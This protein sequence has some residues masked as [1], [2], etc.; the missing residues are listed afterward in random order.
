MNQIKLEII[1]LI[2]K[3]Q[4]IIKINIKI[5]KFSRN[6]RNSQVNKIIKHPKNNVYLIMEMCDGGD[7]RSF[8]KKFKGNP[9]SEI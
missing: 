3:N 1:R 5:T 8:M 9:M 6:K 2:W 7:L 4:D